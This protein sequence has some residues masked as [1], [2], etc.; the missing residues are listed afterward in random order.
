LKQ[1]FSQK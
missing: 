1:H